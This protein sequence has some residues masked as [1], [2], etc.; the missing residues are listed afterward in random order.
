MK[1]PIYL[2][3]WGT[4]YRAPTFTSFDDDAKEFFLSGAEQKLGGL[5]QVNVFA[6]IVH[7]NAIDFH[8][9]LFDKP[10][11]LRF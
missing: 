5:A 6:G 9:T 10:P 7:T 3:P 8:S 4:I 11:S 2:Q 1:P